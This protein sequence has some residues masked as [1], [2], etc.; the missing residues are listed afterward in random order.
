VKVCLDEHYSSEI[1]SQLRNR[2]HDIWSVKERPE[3]V[4]VS[5]EELWSRMRTEQRALLTENVQDFMPLVQQTAA[6]GESHYGVIFSSSRSMP[7]SRATIGIFIERLEEIL[8]RPPRDEDFIDHVEWL[9][10]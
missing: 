8:A 1:S 9:Q 2:G 4:A 3:F 10:P 6:L 7:R 5:D